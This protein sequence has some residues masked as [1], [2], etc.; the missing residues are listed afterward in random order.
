MKQDKANPKVI[1][2]YGDYNGFL[3]I[4]YTPDGKYEQSITLDLV[5]DKKNSISFY[6]IMLFDDEYTG[7]ES[8][9]GYSES[10]DKEY[11]KMIDGI[12]FYE[13]TDKYFTHRPITVSVFIELVREALVNNFNLQEKL[14]H[15]NITQ[16]DR[17]VYYSQKNLND[18]CT[19][20]ESLQKYFYGSKSIF[21]C[22]ANKANELVL[23][24]YDYFEFPLNVLN[25]SWLEK[26]ELYELLISDIPQEISRL[27]NLTSLSL[28]LSF[29]KELPGAICTLP[30]L[31]VLKLERT[32]MEFFPEHLTSL[33]NLKE[34][35]LNNNE[36]I[37]ELPKTVYELEQ[38]EYLYIYNSNFKKLSS[39][40]CKLE[41]LSTLYLA[42]NKIEELPKEI[43]CL[44]KLRVLML[45]N[46]KLKSIPSDLFEMKSIEK[47]D[48]SGN[49]YLN[50]ELVYDM[51]IKA[52]RMNEIELKA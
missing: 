47:I 36:L 19:F 50:K 45:N 31:E 1:I 51:L 46:N 21:N 33:K 23:D 39:S 2:R 9:Y 16:K 13:Q 15:I 7:V 4:E 14:V 10:R 26:L 6:T 48:L 28:K 25:F 37:Y 30:K 34:L 24:D 52:G 40:I 18:N 3:F 38:L 49:N 29:L 20:F 12:P 44:P 32:S 5:N 42:D 27:K 22:W 35:H 41:N 17:D 43:T 11:S 8:T